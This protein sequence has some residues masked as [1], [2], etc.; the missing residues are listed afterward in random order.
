MGMQKTFL[1]RMEKD[2]QPFLRARQLRTLDL[3]NQGF[4]IE[5][6]DSII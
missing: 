1:L 2:V 3:W 6:V 4:F 5:L